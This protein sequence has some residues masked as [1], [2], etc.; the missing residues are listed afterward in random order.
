MMKTKLLALALAAGSAMIAAPAFAASTT[1]TLTVTATVLG[2]C[3]FNAAGPTTLTI[4]TGAG[5]IDPSTAGPATGTANVTFRCTTGTTSAI[6][7][8]N[9]LNFSGGSR[10]VRNGAANYMPYAFSMVN[11]AQLGTGH[12]AGQDK[13]VQVNASIIA[14]DYQNATAGAYTDTVVLT[15][16]P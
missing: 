7:G 16:T 5:V 11:A 2:T 12:G 3:K 9:G 14:T 13:T 10:R 8:D 4:A 1:H 15:I 6:T